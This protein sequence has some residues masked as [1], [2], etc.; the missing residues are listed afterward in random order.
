MKNYPTHQQ[1]SG[2]ERTIDSTSVQI[3]AYLKDKG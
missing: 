1:L 3:E 2:A